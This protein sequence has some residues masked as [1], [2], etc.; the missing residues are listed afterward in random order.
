MKEINYFDVMGYT[1]EKMSR[2]GVVLN[3][4]DYTGDPSKLIDTALIRVES[5]SFPIEITVVDAQYVYRD[6]PSDVRPGGW[7]A[8]PFFQN[9]IPEGVYVGQSANW[10][11][12]NKFCY[13]HYNFYWWDLMEQQQ[14]AETENT[15]EPD[16][17]GD[18]WDDVFDEDKIYGYD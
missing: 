15:E 14:N 12:Y 11:F 4:A 17:S 7:W 8:E 1:A 10:T 18:S 6:L 5:R 2:G 13:D 9:A 16:D 3:V